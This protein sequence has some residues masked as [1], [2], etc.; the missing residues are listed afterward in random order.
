MTK[1]GQDLFAFGKSL[2][3][4]AQQFNA[5]WE[6]QRLSLEWEAREQQ[7][8]LDKARIE[9]GALDHVACDNCAWTGTVADLNE[10]KSLWER[11]G[12][13][14]TLPSGE[15]PK[16]GALAYPEDSDTDPPDEYNR[17]ASVLEDMGYDDLEEDRKEELERLDRDEQ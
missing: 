11:C 3:K 6:D 2:A 15:C 9:W 4:S 10:A 8:A 12:T 14:G 5:D 16:C 17:A 7:A 13:D 1:L